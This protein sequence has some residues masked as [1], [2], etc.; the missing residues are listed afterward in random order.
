MAKDKSDENYSLY[1]SA[2]SSPDVS[3]KLQILK[4][5]SDI[6]K[7]LSQGYTRAHIWKT[8]VKDK[9]TECSFPYF[10]NVVKKEILSQLKKKEK[11]NNNSTDSFDEK[12][13]TK[14]EK[15][16]SECP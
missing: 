16:G 10:N 5:S 9:Q 11:P 12:E 15:N 14:V 6:K 8:L 1:R 2:V 13:E 3:K 4:H 7:L